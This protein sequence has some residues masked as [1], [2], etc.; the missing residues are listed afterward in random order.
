[1]SATD[2]TGVAVMMQQALSMHQR[3]QFNE[4]EKL[5][6]QVLQDHPQHFDALHLL[7]V[8]ARQGGH[9]QLALELI[10]QALQVD[11]HQAVAHCNIGV[12]LQ[13]LNQPERALHHYERALE[14]NPNYAVALNN[15]GNTLRKLQRY[16]EAL[17]SYEE[18]L[19]CK[20]DYAEAYYNHATVLHKLR[21]FDEAL[22]GFEQALRYKPDYPDAWCNHGLALQMLQRYEEAL[23]SYEQALQ[24]APQHAASWCNRGTVLRKMQRYDEALC[25][26]DLALQHAPA[27]ADAHLFRGNTLRALSRPDEAIASY[28]HALEH[29]ADPEQVHYALAALG[30]EAAPMASPADYV[31]NLFD[32]YADH[33]DNHLQDVL[34]YRTPELLVAAVRKF[35]VGDACDTIDLGCGTGLCGPLL[36]PFSRSLVGVDLSPNML[37]KALQREIYDQLACGDIVEFLQ[38]K[39]DCYD[40]AVAA[41]VLVYVGDLAPVFRMLQGALRNGSVFAFS[42]EDHDGDGFVLRASHRFAHSADY[43]TSMASDFGFSIEAM[44]SQVLRYDDGVAINGNLAL[45]TCRK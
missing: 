9:P 40:L 29:G 30:A 33:F 22:A 32:R 5:Y 31:K 4:A 16:D 39:I 27:M 36:K 17:R 21:R 23:A 42:V 1:M 2:A 24:R 28:R 34:H 3:G 14:L 12:A 45:M 44:E 19:R 20:P 7:G 38:P 25:C 41:D 18:A 8:L 13:D 6:R 35:G 10:G 26:Y 43:L 37:D 11:P 15:R